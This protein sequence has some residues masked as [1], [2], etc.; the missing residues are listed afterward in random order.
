MSI[1]DLLLK[2]KNERN[3]I[4]QAKCQKFLSAYT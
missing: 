4:K 2:D 3:A 1:A